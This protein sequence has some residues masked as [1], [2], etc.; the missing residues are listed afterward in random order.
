MTHH[1]E[2]L[3]LSL[4]WA[5]RHA[6]QYLC[7]HVS[8]TSMQPVIRRGDRVWVECVSPDVLCRGDLVVIQR[9]TGLVTHRLVARHAASCLTKGDSCLLLDPPL[10]MLAL[11]GRVVRIERG[12]AHIDLRRSPWRLT[13]RWLGWLGWL[14][15]QTFQAVQQRAGGRLA[16]LAVAPIWLL[17]HLLVRCAASIAAKDQP[18][19]TLPR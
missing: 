6:S 3:T 4:A 7:L 2:A 10:P 13:N 1:D 8:G 5:H 12:T 17:F 18:H 14:Q 19:D 9:D 16:R 11:R 15:G